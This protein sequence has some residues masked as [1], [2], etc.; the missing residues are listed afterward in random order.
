[1]HVR[2]ILKLNANNKEEALQ[3]AQSYI[4]SSI[5]PEE[6]TCGWDY[7]GECEIL[8]PCEDLEE[9]YNKLRKQ[10]IKEISERIRSYLIG[11]LIKYLPLK[12][13]PLLLDDYDIKEDAERVLKDKNYKSKP[14]PDNF[15]DL[16]G[17]L[18]EVVTELSQ[19]EHIF[20]Y[21]IKQINKIQDC[22]NNPQDPKV[23]LQCTDNHFADL[24]KE[25]SGEKVFYVN[26]DR[27]V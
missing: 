3:V 2:C 17:L 27:H 14:L 20:Q 10:R 13:A 16:I 26:T 15:I 4:E 18:T 8:I 22:I 1:M 24:T 25:T 12:E 9:H 23:C 21:Y 11:Y 7:A 19:N 6:N 5:E